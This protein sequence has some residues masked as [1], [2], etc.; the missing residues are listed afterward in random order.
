VFSRFLVVFIALFIVYK[1]YALESLDFQL[2]L[3]SVNKLLKFGTWMTLSNLVGPLMV[4]MDRFIVANISGTFNIAFYT[5]PQDFVIR[6]LII[7]AAISTALFP[8]F[9]LLNA[10]SIDHK[11]EYRSFYRKGLWLNTILMGIVCILL[12]LFAQ[13]LLS[14]W[15]DEKFALNATQVSRI[16]I[17]GVFFNSIAHIPLASLQSKGGV[18]IT[19]LLHCVELVLYI[20]VLWYFVQKWGV[21]GAA[22]TW[23]LRT[24]LDLILL[25]IF[26][27]K[28]NVIK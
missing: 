8:R 9:T 20:P 19:A 14:F 17:V 23:T 3:N 26:D 11:S 10:S 22:I 21:E 12:F 15:I 25:I 2:D 1:K 6:L 4:M 13:P 5:V 27:I 24:C 18:K 16:L 7:P 28:K